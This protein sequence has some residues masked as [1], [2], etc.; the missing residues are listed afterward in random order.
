MPRAV[1]YEW[2]F[3]M[4]SLKDLLMKATVDSIFM[5][6]FGVELNTFDGSSTEELKQLKR[7]AKACDDSNDLQY[8]RTAPEFCSFPPQKN[9]LQEKEEDLLSRF[10][11]LTDKDPQNV[12]DKYL[13]DI[14]LNFMVAGKDTTAG[15]LSWFFYMMCRH[16]HIQIN[17]AKDIKNAAAAITKLQ[18][19]L[20]ADFAESLSDRVMQLLQRCFNRILRSLWY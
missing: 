14:I 8:M 1:F 6:G 20:M 19:Q 11:L 18:E 7:F 15:T 13:R 2:T 4:L 17:F 3:T 16:T 12:T 9:Q 5:V 10:L